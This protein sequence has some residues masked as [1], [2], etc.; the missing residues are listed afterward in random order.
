MARSAEEQRPHLI[1]LY[2][3]KVDHEAHL[4]GPES[5]ETRDAVK[6]VDAALGRLFERVRSTKLPVNIVVVSDHGMAQGQ[7]GDSVHGGR[8]LRSEI[9]RGHDPD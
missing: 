4:H 9:Q 6:E 2:I 5:T 7:A 8:I 1:L 3:S